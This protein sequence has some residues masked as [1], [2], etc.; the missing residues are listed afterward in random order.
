MNILQILPELNVG[1]VETGTV[2]LARRLVKLG[3]K[4]VVVSAGGPMVEE[5]VAGGAIHYQLP[6]HKKSIFHILKMIPKLVEIIQK[7]DIDVVHARS[8][9]P[10][11]IA[12]YACRRANKPFITT[13]H[14]YY[15]KHL[16]SRA[17]GWGKFVICPGKVIARHM[18]EDFD[19]PLER[20]RLVPRSV[21]IEKFKFWDPAEK[22]KAKE[23]NI[24]II[25]RITPLKG[26]M[27]FIKAMARLSR[28]IPYLKIW[29][30]GDAP[31]SK[32]AYKEQLQV[33]VR[34][35]ALWES[36]QFLGTQRDMP[37]VLKNLDLV[38]LA[39][40]THDA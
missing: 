18:A 12:Y 10:A 35:L 19:V 29:I 28:Q 14:G 26:H 38:V 5:L 13:C 23:F 15:S 39:S 3:H 2:D 9:V 37:E 7:E 20:I 33:L 11:W 1:G 25:G 31:A 8:R 24:G 17:M 6:V 21:D 34:R 32:S 36:T 16:F 40:K 30:V 27:D 22:R 4:A